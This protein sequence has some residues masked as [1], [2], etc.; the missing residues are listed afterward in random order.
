MTPQQRRAAAR[1]GPL[2]WRAAPEW[3]GHAAFIICGGP[4]VAAQN[5]ALLAGAKVIVINSSL[6]SYP[7]ADILYFGDRRWWLQHRDAVAAFEGRAVTVA[8]EVQ[9]PRILRMKKSPPPGLS[10]QSD[11]LMQRRTSATAAINLAVHLGANPIVTLGLDGKATDG[12][13][14]HHAPHIWP[15]KA[16]RFETWMQDLATLADPLRLRGIELLNASPGSAVPFWPVVDLA[17][18][19]TQITRHAA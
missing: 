1:G 7:Q 8:D 2:S 19:M 14:W 5:L 4:S 13:H 17:E 3:Q 15:P 16:D 10:Q 9:D 11:T 6:F 18:V 12:R